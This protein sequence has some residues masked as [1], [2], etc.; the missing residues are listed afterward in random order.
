VGIY[1]RKFTVD[2]EPALQRAID[3]DTFHPGE[4]KV[5]HFKQPNMVTQVMGDSSGPIV[6]VRFTKTLRISCVWNDEGDVHRNARAVILGIHD[7][8]EQARAS[9]YTEIIITTNHDK[10]ANFFTKV[11][12][13]TR[14]GDEYILQV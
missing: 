12:K 11:M 4:W 5:E 6:F 1:T 2:D 8:V 13:M 9:G 7:A 14:S 3:R 10:L